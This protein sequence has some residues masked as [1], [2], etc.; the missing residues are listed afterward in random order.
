MA[1]ITD[2]LQTLSDLRKS[3]VPDGKAQIGTEYTYG[4]LRVSSCN[5]NP[6]TRTPDRLQH[7]HPA[8]CI[9]AQQYSSATSV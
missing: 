2:T 1:K 7:D 8:A 6:N 5:P 4:Q 3:E 9:I